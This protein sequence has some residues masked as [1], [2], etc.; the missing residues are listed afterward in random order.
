MQ[1]YGQ[2]NRLSIVSDIASH[3][4]FTMNMGTLRNEAQTS[5]ALADKVAI[6][7]GSS[8]GIG[9]AIAVAFAKEGACVVCAD[10]ESISRQPQ[11]QSEGTTLELIGKSGGRATFQ[12]TDVGK[13]DQMKSLIE[14]AVQEYGRLDM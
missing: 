8:S 6:V 11:E 14:T 13:P 10:L 12:Q 2:D 4:F 9:R 3:I 1:L 5:G 7:T